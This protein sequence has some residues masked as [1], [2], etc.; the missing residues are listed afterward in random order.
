[1]YRVLREVYTWSATCGSDTLYIEEKKKR[2]YTGQ[3]SRGIILVA[4]IC[5]ARCIVSHYFDD[6][7][8]FVLS[9]NL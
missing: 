8:R 1:M 7:N 2:R 5:D 4:T 6:F 3:A 9:V